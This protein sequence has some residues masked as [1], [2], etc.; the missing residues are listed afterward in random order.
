MAA[1][2]EAKESG[3]V[4]YLLKESKGEPVIPGSAGGWDGMMTPPKK[5]GRK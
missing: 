5:K 1:K 4:G 3:L 2:K